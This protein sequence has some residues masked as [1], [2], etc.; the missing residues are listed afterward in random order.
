MEVKARVM[1]LKGSLCTSGKK[2]E[3]VFLRPLG[4]AWTRPQAQ[5]RPFLAGPQQDQAGVG[6]RG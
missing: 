2:M 3:S 4:R 6:M 5:G 1:P